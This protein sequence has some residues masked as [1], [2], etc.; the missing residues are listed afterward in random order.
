MAL[1]KKRIKASTLM[2]TLVATVL[3]V[4]IFM[5]SSMLLNNLLFNN[6]RQNTEL[7]QERLHV[8]EYQYKNGGIQL[9]YYEDFEPWEIKISKGDQKNKNS[10]MLLAENRKTG[11]TVTNYISGEEQ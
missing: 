2:E 10:V 8:L 4:I 6:M 7:A 11:K 3:I 5:I 1:L 9:P